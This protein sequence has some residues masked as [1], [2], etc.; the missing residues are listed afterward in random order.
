MLPDTRTTYRT[1]TAWANDNA[2]C[3]YVAQ[4]L[5]ALATMR[6][7]GTR[8]AAPMTADALVHQENDL[9]YRLRIEAAATAIS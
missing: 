1:G 5:G 7:A 6:V 4:G 9:V 2:R 3:F 8:S